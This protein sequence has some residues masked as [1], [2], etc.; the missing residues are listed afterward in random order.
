MN[1]EEQLKTNVNINPK[2]KVILNLM[3]T[4]NWIN[5]KS[6]DFFKRFDLT[7]QQYNVLRI[8]RGQKGNPINLQDIQERMISRMSNTTRLIEKLKKKELV[9]RVICEENR[10]KIEIGITKKGTSLLSEIDLYIIDHENNTT[11]QLSEEEAFQ[12]NELLNKLRT[13]K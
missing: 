8:L 3:Y 11:A 2:T 7:S 9:T 4:G 6:S 13:N 1:I 12:L 10:R 5:E